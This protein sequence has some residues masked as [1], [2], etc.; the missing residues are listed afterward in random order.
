MYVERGKYFVI[1]RG[2]QY[3][4]TTTLQALADYLEDDY[5]VVS[6]DFQG[7]GA[8]ELVDAETFVCVGAKHVTEEI[9]CCRYWC[10]IYMAV[11][12]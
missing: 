10:K 5:I 11:I 1:N 7:I 4:K 12:Y 9:I 3:G 8:E 6:I 2:R